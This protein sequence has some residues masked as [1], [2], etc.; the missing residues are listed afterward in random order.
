MKIIK[1]FRPLHGLRGLLAAPALLLLVYG[2]GPGFPIVTE[3]QQDLIDKVD[4]ATKNTQTLEARVV[5]LE[6]R[7]ADKEGMAELKSGLAETTKAVEDLSREFAFVRGSIEESGNARAQTASEISALEEGARGMNER[8]R[9]LEAS[10]AASMAGIS[11]LKDELAASTKAIDAIEQEIKVLTEALQRP[12]DTGAAVGIEEPAGPV[13]RGAANPAAPK[14]EIKKPAA[15]AAEVKKEAPKEAAKKEDPDALYFKG[16]KL[17]KD[18]DFDKASAAFKHFLQLYPR[19]KL[20][21]HA[22]YWLGEIYYSRGNWERA[23]LEFDKVIKE[24]PGGDKVPAAILKEGFSFD[25]LGSGKEARLLLESVIE[26]Y[27]E[28]P[29]AKMAAE[30]LE[31]IKK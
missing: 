6:G 2:C 25:K 10:S 24:Y 7:G 11:K 5:A 23:I 17:T 9:V 29:E 27:P 15:A 1:K 18:K 13:E 16:F 30:R 4:K 21:D 12:A 14:E 19:N 20:A 8:L 26:K 22:R 28:S 31:K 3:E